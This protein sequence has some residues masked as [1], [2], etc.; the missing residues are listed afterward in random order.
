MSKSNLVLGGSR[1]HDG[2]A[3]GKLSSMTPE[4]E[5]ETHTFHELAPQSRQRVSVLRGMAEM[6]HKRAISPL[7]AEDSRSGARL[8]EEHVYVN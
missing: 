2:S 6:A 1:L 8:E 7:L 3:T 5:N 4:P